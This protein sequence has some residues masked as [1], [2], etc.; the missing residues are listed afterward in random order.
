M[1][2]DAYAQILSKLIQTALVF[3]TDL[4]V[5]YGVFGIL[6]A[7]TGTTLAGHQTLYLIFNGLLT[8]IFSKLE[9]KLLPS[10]FPTLSRDLPVGICMISEK[11]QEL[12][13]AG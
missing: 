4:L 12:K 5:T 8:V 10:S 2:Q 3:F 9:K 7:I 1:R 6:C 13:I 11:L